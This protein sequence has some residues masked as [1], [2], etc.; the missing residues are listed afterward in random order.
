MTWRCLSL[1]LYQ[2]YSQWRV[3]WRRTCAQSLWSRWKLQVQSRRRES[4]LQD[5]SCSI[6]IKIERQKE[7]L[8]L[9]NQRLVCRL[10][11]I[12]LDS[13]VIFSSALVKSSFHR[14]DEQVFHW[15]EMRSR[16]VVLAPC[17]LYPWKTVRYLFQ[18][19]T[20]LSSSGFYHALQSWQIQMKSRFAKSD[21]GI[22]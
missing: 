9:R 18:S 20:R 11:K 5:S 10:R 1:A 4:S 19:Q 6:W 3:W 21:Q 22:P 15:S 16:D 14:S 12:V 17:I 8:L 13:G 2:E 7:Y